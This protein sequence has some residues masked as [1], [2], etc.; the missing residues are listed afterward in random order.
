[1]ATDVLESLRLRLL[2]VLLTATLVAAMGC[3]S[4]TTEIIVVREGPA[5]GATTQPEE[6]AGPGEGADAGA[7][8][9]DAA[10]GF[11]QSVLLRAIQGK[12]YLTSPAFSKASE[13]FA[14]AVT[15]NT[16]VTEWISFQALSAYTAITPDAGPSRNVSAMPVGTVIVRAVQDASGNV[17][18]LTVMCKGPQ[19]F[20]PELGDWWFGVT[21][22]NGNPLVDDGGVQELGKLTNCYGCHVPHES[23]DFLFGV[24]TASQVHP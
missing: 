22:P 12:A 18:K 15:P 11:D 5:P 1:M 14:S 17:T 16:W 20:N 4:P 13:T 8:A 21:D 10:N 23:E 3:S 19:G 2:L 6:D 24:P 9:T 7:P